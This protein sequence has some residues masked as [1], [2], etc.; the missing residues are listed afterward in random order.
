MLAFTL[1]YS[2]GER[3]S[4]EVL[5]PGLGKAHVHR[6]APALQ[7]SYSFVVLRTRVRITQ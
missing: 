2:G 5:A 7:T 4:T 6:I 1:S 3:D